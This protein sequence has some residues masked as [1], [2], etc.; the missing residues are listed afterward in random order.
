MSPTV[1]IVT[2]DG[3][4][5]GAS[6]TLT[7]PPTARRPSPG[8]KTHAHCDTACRAL[9]RGGGEGEALRVCGWRLALPWF[10]ELLTYTALRKQL[11]LA[12]FC[13]A[14]AQLHRVIVHASLV[15]ARSAFDCTLAY[16]SRIRIQHRQTFH[17][18]AQPVARILVRLG[19]LHRSCLNH[20]PADRGLAR[21]GDARRYRVAC[22]WCFAS[23]ETLPVT[24]PARDAAVSLLLGSQSN[25]PPRI[26]ARRV[27]AGRSPRA[28]G[29]LLDRARCELSHQSTRATRAGRSFPAPMRQHRPA[30][31]RSG[32]RQ[33][34]RQR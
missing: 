17:Y 31:R 1:S 33:S 23:R 10:H 3:G 7:R 11:V 13:R 4:E 14:H 28:L 19:Y 30:R 15:A 12:G 24:G 9:R 21:K 5:R 16:L 8:G 25:G 26:T 29:C 22:N 27:V 34:P 2:V 20:Y 6:G 18:S 32:G